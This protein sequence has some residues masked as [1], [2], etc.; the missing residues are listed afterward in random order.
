VICLP[1]IYW[2]RTIGVLA[3]LALLCG[4]VVAVPAAGKAEAQDVKLFTILHTND[5]H[6]ELIPY[7]PA[8]DYPTY[9]TYGGISRIAHEIGRIKGEKAAANEPVL[10]LSAGDYNQGTLFG[11]LETQAAA[12]LVLMQMIGYD[13]IA[14]GNHDF[15]MGAG[16][17]AMAW[18]FA[19]ALP[20]A[21][22]GPINIPLLCA[23]IYFDDTDPD[24]A[25]L[26]AL[27]SATD[28]QG[29]ELAIQPYTVKTL[30]NGL[31][32]GI[33]GLLGVEAEAVAPTAE[34]TGVTFGNVA[35]NP[36]DP[37]SFI[38]R[39]IVAQ[40]MVNTLKDPAIGNCD[41]VVALSHS[42]TTEEENLAKFVTGIDVIVGGHS[43]DLNYPPILVGDT[44]IVQAGSY[45]SHL[46]V[47]ELEYA[48]GK[49][50][51]RNANAIR[52]DDSIPTVPAI[53]GFLANYKAGLDAALST[54]ILA[55]MAE[56]DLAGDGGFNISDGPPF[57]ETNLGNLVTDAYRAVVTAIDP[58]KPVDI[59]FEGNGVIRSG[60][61][62]GGLGHFSLYDL[63]RNIPLGVDLSGAQ[64]QPL[65]YPLVSFYLL[66]GEILGVME[67]TLDMGSNT[68]FLQISGAR[69]D[70]RPAAPMGSKIT[71]FEVDDG[72]GGWQPINPGGLY[73]VAT[74]L[75]SG[76]FLSAFGLAPRD[77]TGATTNI[78]ACIVHQ[79]PA[80]VKAWQALY[81]YV[82]GMPDLDGDGLPNILPDYRFRQLRINAA[83]WYLAEGSTG[84]GMETFVLVQNPGDDDVMVNVKFQTG[85][86][87]VA[88]EMLQGITIPANSRRTFK[89]NDWVTTFDVSTMVEPIDGDV[90]V[91]RAMYGDGRTWAHDS[92]GVTT[93]SPSQ[94]WFLAEGS[95]G[96]GME[97][98][99]LVQNPFKSAAHINI[100]FQTDTGKVA[101]ADLQGVTIPASSRATFN[102]GQWVPDNYNV[103]TY[104]LAEDGLIV[105]E[106]AMYGDGRT[107]A[108][109][110]I[111]TP[112]ISDE[113]FLAEGSTDGGMETFVLVQNPGDTAV[114]V[115]VTFNTDIGDMAPLDLQGVTIPA[116]S[117]R[118]FKVNDWVTNYNVSTY[119]KCTDGAVVVERAMYGD[120]R[121]WAHDSI[122]AVRPADTW[123]LAEGST[124][125]GME[126]FVLVQNPGADAA[127]V[128]I[129]FQTGEGEVAAAALQGVTIPAFSRRTFKVNDWVTTFDVSTMVVATEGQVVV[130]RAMYGNDRTWAHNSIG[131]VPW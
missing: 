104:V 100:V 87:E 48:G 69:Y 66:G 112:V 7:G 119:V 34:A 82:A 107:W 96:G 41:V 5:E 64:P 52:M 79:G 127:K 18:Q 24:A 43:H 8:S 99:L 98:W 120:D 92:I 33:F 51:L 40:N 38:N 59:G 50:S 73:K 75:Y 106:R 63:Y 6:S 88:P 13:A 90:I 89:A 84:G 54:D 129:V 74:N 49:V 53:D 16:Y 115:N 12:E 81:Q 72:A 25:A 122:G 27:Y 37:V 67:A 20:P 58:T 121:T 130:E 124:D 61:P 23:N 29:T 36:T 35:G 101:P 57:V 44:I 45:T 2:K 113:W 108:H 68:F 125:G 71:S 15:D 19:K 31:K 91:E 4:M 14:V 78:F 83:G 22:G 114:K 116:N 62:K 93:P 86:G 126:T 28:K 111:G 26:K 94:E 110:S 55:P 21:Q 70:Y 102:V 17:R 77:E 42:G 76:L 105:C 109:D 39:V 56:T 46:G 128:N 103:S 32:V 30:A 131:Y 117:R 95:T 80:Q 11:W 10:T 47:L 118:T 9:P 123:Y 65:G 85:E 1:K 3:C 97:T 60:I